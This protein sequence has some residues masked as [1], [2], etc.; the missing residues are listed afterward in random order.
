MLEL[1]HKGWVYRTCLI[2]LPSKNYIIPA[3]RFR[4]VRGALGRFRHKDVVNQGNKA[5]YTKRFK[6][7]S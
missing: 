7:P 5:K 1:A 4:C 3:L 6:E 2:T